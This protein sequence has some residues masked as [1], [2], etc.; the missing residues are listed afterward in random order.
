M[1]ASSHIGLDISDRSVKFFELAGRPGRY[2]AGSYGEIGI[3]AGVIENGAPREEGV[4]AGL[5]KSAGLGRRAVI[6]SLPDEHGFIRTL[7]F[8][9]LG[10]EDLPRAVRWELEGLVPVPFHD[11]IYDY[12]SSPEGRGRAHRKAFVIAYPKRLIESY[13]G[14][15]AA[16]GLRPLAFEPESQAIARALAAPGA[17]V[18][19]ADIGAVNTSLAVIC[20]GEFHSARSIAFGGR[21]IEE[22]VSRELGVSAEKA[23]VIKEEHGFNLSGR[24]RIAGLAPNLFGPL[25]SAIADV[26]AAHGVAE[27]L[28]CGGESI[29]A[30]IDKH[31]AI[32]LDMLVRR[33]N[34]F[35]RLSFGP[36]VM[37]PITRADAPRYAVAV[38]L[39][40][41][42]FI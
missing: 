39:A 37:P 15:L 40:M 18:A 14:V 8:P 12:R 20:S 36:G 26:R 4:L 13:G 11:L 42:G 19:I 30:G 17:S 21:N 32:L 6:A 23:R 10:G 31:L 35:S 1:G 28:L 5:L 33:G 7:E 38:G 34:P 41:R 3:P 22:A 9:E 29:L 24:G 27:V 2:R 16:A 25:I